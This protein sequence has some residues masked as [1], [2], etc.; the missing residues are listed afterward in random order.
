MVLI[1]KKLIDWYSVPHRSPLRS[2]YRLDCHPDHKYSDE[3]QGRQDK[4]VNEFVGVH[5]VDS[6]FD[7][8]LDAIVVEVEIVH[9]VTKVF[10]CLIEVEAKLPNREDLT[11]FIGEHT[12]H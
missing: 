7:N 11:V 3:G 12:L 9:I 6:L 5:G 8:V 4:A 10:E 1:L 2:L